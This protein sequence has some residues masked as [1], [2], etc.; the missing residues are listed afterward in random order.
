MSGLSSFVGSC[1]CEAP[2]L[3]RIC[4]TS[5]EAASSCDVCSLGSPSTVES[6]L[7]L[8]SWLLRTPAVYFC[9]YDLLKSHVRR[10]LL[11]QVLVYSGAGHV[12]VEGDQPDGAGDVQ[13]PGLGAHGRRSYSLEFREAGKNRL[14]GAQAILPQLLCFFCLQTRCSVCRRQGQHPLRGD[15]EYDFAYP[16]FWKQRLIDP[17]QNAGHT[18]ERWLEFCRPQHTRYP[19]PIFLQHHVACLFR[20]AGDP[21]G[22]TRSEREDSR[23]RLVDDVW[24]HRAPA[25]DTS[26]QDQDVRVRRAFGLVTLCLWVLLHL[27]TSKTNLRHSLDS[28]SSLII[29]DITRILHL[30]HTQCTSP[31]IPQQLILFIANAF[32]TVSLLHRRTFFFLALNTTHCSLSPPCIALVDV[33]ILALSLFTSLDITCIFPHLHTLLHSPS[34]Y[35]TEQNSL[36]SIK[37]GKRQEIKKNVTTTHCAI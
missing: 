33:V 17:R 30:Y 1:S 31:Y 20:V 16:E 29:I 35:L 28:V 26:P 15:V 7:S 34:R 36:H 23:N 21:C 24:C 4:P 10:H 3:Y 13:L 19:L 5:N 8:G 22:W 9:I 6:S 25:G 11:E 12:H 32:I 37:I 14:P 18:D 2:L 27:C